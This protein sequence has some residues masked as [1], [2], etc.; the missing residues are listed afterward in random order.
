MLN[1][2]LS[3]EENKTDQP[4]RKI[5]GEAFPI[6]NEDLPYRQL[7]GLINKTI[8]AVIAKNKAGSL[9]I[10]TQYDILQAV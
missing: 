7:T 2:L 5:M 4:I 1:F 8:P 10:L 9:H 6:V 3:D